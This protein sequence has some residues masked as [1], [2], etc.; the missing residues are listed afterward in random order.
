MMRRVLDLPLLVILMGITALIM[1]LPAL[2]AFALRDLAIA[3]AFFY[4]ATIIFAVTVMVALATANRKV[5]DMA[6]GHLAALLA[7]YLLLPLMLALP[8]H[9]AVVG[10]SFM[11]AWF[12][13]VSALTTTG[14]TLFPDVDALRP[15]LHLWRA[16]VGW[17][18]GLL[19][20]IAALAILAPLNLGGA[21]VVSGRAPGGGR[22]DQRVADPSERIIRQAVKITPVYTALT[23]LLWGLLLGAGESG[24][25]ALCH[26]MAI[27][28]SS[29]ISPVG[30]LVGG[31]SGFAG[32][33]IVLVF[34]LFA[35]T[36]RALPGAGELYRGTSLARDP[37]L[38]VAASIVVMVT[39][40]L[41][42]RHWFSVLDSDPLRGTPG[43]MRAT[44]G[45]VFT[46]MSF[47]TG[48]GFLSQSWAETRFWSG[49]DAPGL[50]LAGLAMIGGGVA[51]TAGGMKLFRIYALFRHGQRQLEQQIH[52]NS[53]GGAHRG[54]RHISREGA[55]L[56]WIF[57]VLFGM[58][59]AATT[60]G[61]SATGQDFDP[62]LAFAIASLTNTG[63]LAEASGF[64]FSGLD[65]LAKGIAAAAMILGRVEILAILVLITTDRWRV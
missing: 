1:Y 55:Y 30:G 59:A 12:E 44:W 42:L 6:R 52:P 43:A 47:L 31:T 37:E 51:T 25:V 61:F 32:E 29:G 15:T 8:M 24:F 41:V 64:A 22:S 50:I 46:S 35:V 3:R 23:I 57:F 48:G 18:G 63:P 10:V 14:A 9:Q 21:E 53:V 65:A 19:I 34:M 58:A 60:L 39:A 36:R 56:A 13:M 40:V 16:L 4:G 38:R 5:A 26:A 2:H 11:D 45:A 17:L 27:L 49:L 62:A 54:G 33:V 20:L 28:S 7:A